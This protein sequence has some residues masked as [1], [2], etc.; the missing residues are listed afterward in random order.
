MLHWRRGEGAASPAWVELDHGRVRVLTAGPPDAPPL[1]LIH[2]LGMS[3]AYWTAYTFPALGGAFRL[4][5]P[6]LPGYGGSDPLPHHT[7]AAYTGTLRALLDRLA[8][9]EPA[10]MLGHSMG[11][12]LALGLAAAD[13]ARVRS[14]T[15]V[16]AAGLPW[17]EPPWWMSLRAAT[18]RGNFQPRLL[19]YGFQAGPFSRTYRECVQMIMAAETPHP[20][21]LARITAP[22]LLVWGAQD[23]QVP[24][25]YGRT[26]ARLL[27]NARLAVGH[28]LGHVP[29]FERPAAFHRLVARFLAEN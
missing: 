27:P 23:R 19:A 15:L 4:L 17:R 6:D 10:H 7:L 28:G 1:L 13:P 2:G 16:G 22:T 26:L 24:L 8:S 25:A 11:G 14:L 5:A 12:Q 18:D 9:Y 20:A 21:A 29:F 3:A